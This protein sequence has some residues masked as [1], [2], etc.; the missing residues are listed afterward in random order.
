MYINSKVEFV[1]QVQ[2][3]NRVDHFTGLHVQ[4]RLDTRAIRRNG[5]RG[6]WQTDGRWT[7]H[8]CL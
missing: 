6:E 7:G 4:V 5:R 8:Q 3:N 2:V 1:R